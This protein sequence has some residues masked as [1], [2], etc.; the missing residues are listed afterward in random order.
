MNKRIKNNRSFY[1]LTGTPKIKHTQR[2]IK[3]MQLAKSLNKLIAEY[4]SE[5]IRQQEK[6]LGI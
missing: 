5:I 3:Q 1:S 2:E 4:W 6:L